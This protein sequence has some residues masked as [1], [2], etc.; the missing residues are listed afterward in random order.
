M[1]LLDK[2]LAEDLNNLGHTKNKNSPWN[3]E[4]LQYNTIQRWKFQKKLMAFDIKFFFQ[5][6]LKRI[7]SKEPHYNHLQWVRRFL[8]Q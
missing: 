2:T 7:S 3:I 6:I 4:N 8:V 5:A 1:Q